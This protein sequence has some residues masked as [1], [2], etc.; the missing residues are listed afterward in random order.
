MRHMFFRLGS[1][2]RR[3]LANREGVSG[4]E[5]ALLLPVMV[6][7]FAGTVDLGEGLMVKR[8]VQQIAATTSDIMAQESS[9]TNASLATL[10]AGAASILEP[11]T[12]TGLKIRVSVLNVSSSLKATVAWSYGYQTTALSAGSASPVTIPTTIAESGVQL[13]VT[14]VDYDMT[15]GFTSLLSSV[16]GMGSYHYAVSEIARPRIGDSITGP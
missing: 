1:G 16:S 5:F 4:I 8:R 11:Y 9:W 7:L 14:T 10:T 3:L 6:L 12:S 13:V 2:V 15:T